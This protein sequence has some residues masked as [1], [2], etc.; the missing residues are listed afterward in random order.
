MQ[1][2]VEQLLESTQ[3]MTAAAED[4]CRAPV[5]LTVPSTAQAAATVANSTTPGTLHKRTAAAQEP[6][7]QTVGTTGVTAAAATDGTASGLERPAQ[8]KLVGCALQAAAA[9][10]VAGWVVCGPVAVAVAPGQ[11]AGAST[12]RHTW[13]VH[14]C[15]KP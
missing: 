14:C 9:A 6:P 10:V 4:T 7:L 3:P 15:S 12:G 2:G 11:V 1:T 8:Q 13:T 5:H